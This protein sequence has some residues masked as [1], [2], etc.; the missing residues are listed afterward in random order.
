MCTSDG[1]DDVYRQCGHDT[2]GCSGPVSRLQGAINIGIP[3]KFVVAD[4]LMQ[5][6][7]VDT[8]ERSK[9]DTFMTGRHKDYDIL[10]A[11]MAACIADLL[12]CG[13]KVW[14]YK[15]ED[16]IIDSKFDDVGS[17]LTVHTEV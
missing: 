7:K 11:R 6:R 15:I 2:P 1:W 8:A 5:K 12:K 4:L 14:R 3:H 16:T 9:S 13:Y 17:L 10:Y